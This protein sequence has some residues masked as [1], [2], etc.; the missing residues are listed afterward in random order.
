M[1]KTKKKKGGKGKRKGGGFERKV[2]NLLSRSIDP[3]SDETLFWRSAMSGGRATIRNRTGKKDDNQAG[4]ITCIHEKG[5]WLTNAFAIEC[6]FY[7]NLNIQSSIISNKGKLIK[8]WKQA[9]EQAK[10]HGKQPLLI[11]KEN[12][13]PTL[14]LTNQRGRD[15]L[16]TSI[17]DTDRQAICC[18]WYLKDKNI[19]VYDFEKFLGVEDDSPNHK[20]SSSGRQRTK[21]RQME[22]VPM[23]KK[24]NPKVR[25][26]SA[27]DTGGSHRLKRSTR[28]P[29]RK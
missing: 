7:A 19:W 23:A 18:I 22:P 11:A 28:S 6:K 12:N 17:L 13:T 29:S 2:C 21:R 27:S 26:R 1:A 10:R 5:A 4:D 9:V 25:G 3:D 8:F 15:F 14:M 16:A 20:R 24:A